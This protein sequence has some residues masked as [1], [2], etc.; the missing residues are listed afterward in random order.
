MNFELINSLIIPVVVIDF[1]GFSIYTIISSAKRE[2]LAFLFSAFK[3][4]IYFSC[5]IAMV[6]NSRTM[7]NRKGENG[8]SCPVPNLR[9]TQFSL[10]Y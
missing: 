2:K 4:F 1:L 10:L 7:L 6:M 9:R 5:L 3:P 8:H